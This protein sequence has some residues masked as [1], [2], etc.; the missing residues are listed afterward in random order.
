ME[1]PNTDFCYGKNI[2]R[3]LNHKDNFQTEWIKDLY[4]FKERIDP[5][6]VYVVFIYI[7]LNPEYAW[8][9]LTNKDS[10]GRKSYGKEWRRRTV[11]GQSKM[12]MEDLTGPDWIMDVERISHLSNLGRASHWRFVPAGVGVAPHQLGHRS[13]GAASSGW[14]EMQF[15]ESRKCSVLDPLDPYL[16][17]IHISRDNNR[18]KTL[19]TMYASLNKKKNDYPII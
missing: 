16:R 18:I 6:F 8:G 10:G 13:R 3:K 9:S 1:N 17:S 5:I 19:L 12:E 11:L 14:S 4:I 2:Q 15:K 7:L